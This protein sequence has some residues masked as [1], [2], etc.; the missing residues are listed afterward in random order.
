M[1][2]YKWK[3]R[4]LFVSVKANHAGDSTS[5]VIWY[6]FLNKN[7]AV[8]MPS[9][10]LATAAFLLYTIRAHQHLLAQSVRKDQRDFCGKDF[11]EVSRLEY[12][13][14][15]FDKVSMGHV[16]FFSVSQFFP[17]RVIPSVFHTRNFLIYD[18]GFINLAINSIGK[19][20]T[21]FHFLHR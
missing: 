8:T 11:R 4:T 12:F 16:F 6:D 20:R 17:I 2:A 1:H 13:G 7:Q 10:R 18:R 3:Y 14:S 15:V 5:R 19:Q 21:F 9:N